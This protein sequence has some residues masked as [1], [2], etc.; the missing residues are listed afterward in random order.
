MCQNLPRDNVSK[1]VFDFFRNPKDHCCFPDQNATLTSTLHASVLLSLGTTICLLWG[2]SKDSCVTVSLRLSYTP[3]ASSRDH[4]FHQNQ[5]CYLGGKAQYV[6]T[7][8]TEALQQDSQ[9]KYFK[10]AATNDC[11][12]SLTLSQMKC[13]CSAKNSTLGSR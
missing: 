3:A 6:D 8:I 11:T 7:A 1:L 5:N 9:T 10:L 13:C 2:K 12:F 4:P